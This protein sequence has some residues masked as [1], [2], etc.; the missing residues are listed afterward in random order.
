[1]N[2]L[3]G[4]LLNLDILPDILSLFVDGFT[5]GGLL[6]TMPFMI[7]LAIGGVYNLIA[8]F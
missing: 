5:V 7:G 3:G 8:R 2:R 1:M 6:C 4:D